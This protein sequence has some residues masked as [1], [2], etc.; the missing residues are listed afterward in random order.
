[1]G[2]IPIDPW[3]MTGMDLAGKEKEIGTGIETGIGNT[4]PIREEGTGTMT[5][6]KGHYSFSVIKPVELKPNQ[7]RGPLRATFITSISR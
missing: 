3:W 7:T 5:P 2:I 1:M 4:T 6:T